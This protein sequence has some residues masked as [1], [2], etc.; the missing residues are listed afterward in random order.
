MSV[1]S[2]ARAMANWVKIEPNVE[3][4]SHRHPHE[5]LGTVLE[6]EIIMTINGETQTLRPGHCYVIAGDV[7]HAAVAG[8]EGCLVLD[9]FSPPREDYRKAAGE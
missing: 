3:V 7:E 5:Q 4:P 8:P 6:G 2:G 9:I 1:L